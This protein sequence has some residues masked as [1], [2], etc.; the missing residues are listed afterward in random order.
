MDERFRDLHSAMQQFG[1][2]K[3]TQEQL[4]DITFRLI[5]GEEPK[6]IAERYKISVAK[7]LEVKHRGY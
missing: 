4:N 1:F 6:A 3:L 5:M 7:V 2:R